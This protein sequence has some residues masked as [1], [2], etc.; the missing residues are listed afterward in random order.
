MTLYY[1][2]EIKPINESNEEIQASVK[3]S[4]KTE[5]NILFY[6]SKGFNSD[7]KPFYETTIKRED[8][9]TQKDSL[10]I[11]NKVLF[12]NEY[13]TP[14]YL[15]EADLYTRTFISEEKYYL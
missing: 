4:D 12:I 9:A 11:V 3:L 1:T 7:G 13:S 2:Y 15:F 6:F 10:I 14:I 8:L 5:Q